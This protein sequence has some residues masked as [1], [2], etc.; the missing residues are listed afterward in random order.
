LVLAL[1][2]KQAEARAI[3]NEIERGWGTTYVVPEMTAW[4]Y[5]A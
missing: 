5:D 2:G 1:Q 3:P 4:T